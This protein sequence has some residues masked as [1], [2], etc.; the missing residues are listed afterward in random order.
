MLKEEGPGSFFKGV[1]PAII[2]TINPVIQYIIYETLK[3]HFIG[4][5]GELA[6]SNIIWISL[7]SKL[8]TTFATYPML[9]VKTLFQSNDKKSSKEILDIIK[10]MFKNKGLI[11]FFEGI[12]AKLAQTLINNTITMLLYEKLQVIIKLMLIEMMKRR[13]NQ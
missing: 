2:M 3:L 13:F 10:K 9:T 4:D 11:G 7:I 8:I 1:F 6:S 5:D 12:S